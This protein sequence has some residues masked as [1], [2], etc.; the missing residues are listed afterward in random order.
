MADLVTHYLTARIPTSRLERPI[1]AAWIAGVLLPD[2][3]CKL[4]DVLLGSPGRFEVPSHMVVGSALYA[5]LASF[6]FEERIRGRAWLAL[7]GGGL[8]HI[9]VD[10]FK[11]TMGS[12]PSAWCLHPFTS[13]SVEFAVYDP[14]DWVWTIP[15]AALVLLA[16]EWRRARDVR[17]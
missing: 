5:Y 8:L 16:W 12:A 11:D 6:A 9:L 1:Q 14:L 4:Y 13:G 7:W 15:V 2:V 17:T 3:V 10:L